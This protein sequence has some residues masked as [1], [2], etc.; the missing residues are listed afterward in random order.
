MTSQ[1]MGDRSDLPRV[2]S[3]GV[4]ASRSTDSWFKEISNLQPPQD[5]AT[6]DFRLFVILKDFGSFTVSPSGVPA[7]FY[8]PSYSNSGQ[9][10]Q[11]GRHTR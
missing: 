4:T 6:S 11:L 10:H 3:R 5:L 9:I 8:G 1:P 2:G 7:L